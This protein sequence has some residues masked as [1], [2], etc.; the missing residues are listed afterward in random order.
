MTNR[1]RRREVQ[2]YTELNVR[3]TEG[4]VHAILAE[5][6]GPDMLVIVAIVALLFGGSQVPKLARSLGSAK[7]E[8]EH[9]L[10]AGDEPP[11]DTKAKGT[12]GNGERVTMT[13]AELDS[14]LAA[15]E[16]AARRAPDH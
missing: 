16:E 10:A 1:G 13:R 7:R 5:I 12:N 3:G 11:A 4:S 2:P 15:K 8:F 14:L 9:G 6:L